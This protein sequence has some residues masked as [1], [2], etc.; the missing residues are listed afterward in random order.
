MAN[1]YTHLHPSYQRDI[2]VAPGALLQF[3]F[4]HGFEEPSMLPQ[5]G[6]SD[7]QSNTDSVGAGSNLSPYPSS[8]TSPSPSGFVVSDG[9]DSS[10]L[11][12]LLPNYPELVESSSNQTRKP[13]KDKPRINLAPDQPTTT[14]GRPRARVFMACVQWYAPPPFPCLVM[15][16]T[17]L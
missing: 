13:R 12:S 17:S 7:I 6:M 10:S 15:S 14:Q 5:F 3:E 16:L 1:R 9:P 11:P 2:S 4:P 8:S